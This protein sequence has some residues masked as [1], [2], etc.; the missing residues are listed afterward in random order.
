MT[1]GTW[2]D[3]RVSNLYLSSSMHKTTSPK[4]WKSNKQKLQLNEKLERGAGSIPSRT[5]VLKRSGIKVPLYYNAYT[6]ET[7]KTKIEMIKWKKPKGMKGPWFES[8]RTK[9]DGQE[10]IIMGK[11]KEVI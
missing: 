2:E 8:H 3:P 11:R 10:Y 1:G 5:R 4:S 9:I 7:V 6:G